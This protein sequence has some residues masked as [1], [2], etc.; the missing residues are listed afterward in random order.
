MGARSGPKLARE[1]N[2]KNA[3]FSCKE[4]AEIFVRVGLNLGHGLAQYALLGVRKSWLEAW[5]KW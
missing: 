5:E 4:W 1:K 3:H 2:P